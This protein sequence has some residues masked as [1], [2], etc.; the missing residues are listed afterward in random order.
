MLGELEESARPFASR[1]QWIDH[2]QEYTQALKEQKQKIQEQKTGV[3][4]LTMHASKGLE[5]DTVLI[6][7]AN[8]GRIPYKRA[9]KEQGAEEEERRLFYVAMTRAK[10]VLRITYVTVKNGRDASPSRFVEELRPE[11]GGRPAG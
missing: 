10:E 6:I 7:Q 3:R 8:E 5:F 1:E 4:L 11:K 2:M 9:L